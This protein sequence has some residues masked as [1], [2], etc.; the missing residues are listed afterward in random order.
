ME[1]YLRLMF[2]KYRYR[3]GYETLSA[4]VSDS[5]T[6][7]GFCRIPLGHPAPHPSTLAKI[8]A[9]CGT[10]AIEGLNH[11]L[12]A[13]AAETGA[14]DLEWLRLDTT[15]VPADIRYPTDSG[16]LT[17][18][19]ARMATLVG[20][21]QAAGYAPRT[22]FDD[23]TA[24]ARAAAHRIGTRLRR[25]TD[26]AKAE[27]LVITGELADLAETSCDQAKRALRD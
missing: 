1:T 18:A 7:L 16:L 14:L 4:E 9:R 24:T 15:V 12:I 26:Q 6:W 27:V 25:R 13:V 21:L 2:L 11:E 23:P 17:R 22:S 19:V 10:A 20:R 8:T 5:L 3:R